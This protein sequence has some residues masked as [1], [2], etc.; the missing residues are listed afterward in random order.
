MLTTANVSWFA[1]RRYKLRLRQIRSKY[2]AN[3]LLSDS[4][5]DGRCQRFP[6]LHC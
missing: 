5:H 3:Q 6:S 1:S 4:E 2:F